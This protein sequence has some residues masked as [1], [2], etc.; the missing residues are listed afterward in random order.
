[1]SK[2]NQSSQSNE[3]NAYY[4][5]IQVQKS[6]NN[7]LKFAVLVLVIGIVAVVF[8]SQSTF[9]VSVPGQTFRVNR[10]YTNPY[11][12]Y[13]AE[14]AVLGFCKYILQ[15]NKATYEDD[16]EKARY[17]AADKV[18][19]YWRAFYYEDP[20]PSTKEPAYY[21]FIK[22]SLVVELEVD[23]SR[24]VETE[25]GF[26]VEMYGRQ[27]F[28]KEF[29]YYTYDEVP[30]RIQALATANMSVSDLN[31]TGYKVAELEMTNES[32]TTEVKENWYGEE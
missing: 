11:R 29:D 10:T 19:N 9:L 15:F 17:L 24:T 4:K 31:R 21:G 1:M 6:S 8:W 25:A 5:A 12:D 2:Q 30:V 16:L 20:Q 18:Y 22:N 13:N 28:R 27:I 23:H 3:L 26:V 7:L 32:W 14:E